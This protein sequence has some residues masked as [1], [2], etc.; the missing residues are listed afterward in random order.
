MN[1]CCIC[2]TIKNCEKYLD[3][4]F[5]N[6]EKITT[7]FDQ[8]IIILACDNSH[9]KSLQKIQDFMKKNPKVILHYNSSPTSN[10]RTVNIAKARNDCLNI[11]RKLYS[12][13]EYFIMMDCD[14]VCASEIDIEPIR[15]YLTRNDWDALSFNREYYYDI[16]AFSRYPLAF[17][18]MH[19]INGGYIWGNY[20]KNL[21]KNAQPKK[22]ISCLSAFN[23]FSIYRT[24]KFIGCEYDGNIRLD[25]IPKNLI[26]Q[27]VKSAGQIYIYIA[28]EKGDCEHRSFH[29]QGIM[30]NGAA[31]R[32]APEIIFQD[33]PLGY[34]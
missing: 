7:L 19:F 29:Y 24:E 12:N 16:W 34:T 17:S 23:G 32:I 30:K 18:Y 8:Y 15:Y 5:N 26:D 21:F 1:S 2:G 28:K 11:I 22:L 3:R 25:L 20:V 31:I 27:N 4:V 33:I 14:N 10:V 6:M 13:Y 9:D